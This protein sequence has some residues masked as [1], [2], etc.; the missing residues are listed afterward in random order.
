ML[1]NNYNPKKKRTL[2]EVW[3]HNS[4]K[5]NKLSKKK[6]SFLMNNIQTRKQKLAKSRIFSSLPN[7]KLDQLSS[8]EK[9]LDNPSVF[10]PR[11]S[12]LNRIDSEN[13]LPMKVIC[14][15]YFKSD[16]IYL[17]FINQKFG[18]F[19]EIGRGSYAIAYSVFDRRSKEEFVLKTQQL[20]KFNKKSRIKRLMVDVIGT[21]D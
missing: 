20:S 13:L 12:V 16:L 8:S 9:L 18:G 19:H 7:N 5:E 11:A 6:Q 14:K 21:R 4:R 1:I 17:P 3:L 10:T 2:P 15:N